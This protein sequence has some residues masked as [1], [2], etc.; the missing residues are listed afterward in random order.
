MEVDR[1]HARLALE[2]AEYESNR[3][4]IQERRQSVVSQQAAAPEKER[5]E[6]FDQQMDGDLFADQD[7]AIE[8]R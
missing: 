5:K 4:S 3:H 8:K 6:W 7:D 1:A 2:R